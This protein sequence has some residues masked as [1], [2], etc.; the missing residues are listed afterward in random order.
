MVNRLIYLF[1]TLFSVLLFANNSLQKAYISKHNLVLE[2]KN[3]LKNSD[4]KASAIKKVGNVRYIFDFKNTILSKDSK[5][6]IK[7]RGNIKSIR[8]GQYKPSVVRVVIDSKKSY[9]LEYKQKSKPIFYISLPA[10]N[11]II[12][13]GI[14]AV[15]KK[16]KQVVETPKQLFNN[17]LYDS[18]K[19]SIINTV[20]SIPSLKNNYTIVID[21]GHGAHDAGAVGGKYREKDIVLSIGKRVY[22]KLKKLGFKVVMTRSRDKFIKLSRRTRMANKLGADMFISIH[23]NSTSKRSRVNIAHGVETY[24]LEQARTARAK[25][26]AAIENRT[27]LHSK[28]S[29]TKNVLLNT[30]FVGPKVLLSNKLAIDVQKGIISSLKGK[31]SYVKDGGVRGAP[32]R[33]LVGAQMP[34]ILIE[35][36]YISNPK[37]RA[38]LLN[39]AYQD[40]LA[41]GVVRG[42]M[43]YFKNRE[44]ELE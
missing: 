8:L 9:K 10:K 43:N 34:A 11:N 6:V 41:N 16:E 35:T 5:R 36:G 31:F 42:V 14:V 39:G 26:I 29:T 4:I 30:V 37:E 38:Y 22:R 33:V 19:S 24:Y 25:R 3:S 15:L 27:L 44:R 21:P 18:P 32:F 17:I 12:K 2:F 13:S 7:L 1:F 23:A 28:D 40:S 20:G